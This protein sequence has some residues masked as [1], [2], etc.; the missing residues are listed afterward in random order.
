MTEI[1]YKRRNSSKRRKSKLQAVINDFNIVLA[2]Q[3]IKLPLRIAIKL[4][5]TSRNK[6]ELVPLL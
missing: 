5:E 3:S 1:Q 6:C 2:Q 4:A